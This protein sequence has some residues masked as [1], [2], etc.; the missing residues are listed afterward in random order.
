MTIVYTCIHTC[1]ARIPSIHFNVLCQL[2]QVFHMLLNYFAPIRGANYCDERVG[3]C[4]SVRSC[5]SQRP[6][7]QTTKF[8]VLVNCGRGSVFLWRQCYVLPVLRMTSR[9]PVIDKA[10][11]TRT[12]RILR[13]THQGAAPGAKS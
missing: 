6:H 7:V 8:S 12:G 1:T 3:M 5:I 10:K 11:A 2:K 13:V 9:L 4:L